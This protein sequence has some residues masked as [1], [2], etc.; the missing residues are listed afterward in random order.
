MTTLA[1][2]SMGMNLLSGANT[3]A[4]V[5]SAADSRFING[6]QM[7][8]KAVY[9]ATVALQLIP[10]LGAVYSMVSSPIGQAIGYAATALGAYMWVDS[11]D[12]K[13]IP[14]AFKALNIAINV[15]AVAVILSEAAINAPL[16]GLNIV[17]LGVQGHEF[18]QFVSG[19][20]GGAQNVNVGVNVNVVNEGSRSSSP[21][22]SD[23]E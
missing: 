4:A 22:P 1:V 15:L 8:E 20:L 18:Y 3:A 5:G 2:T 14:G 7:W 17:C 6:K 10:T 23:K 16:L 19:N 21:V 9:V 12:Q 11:P 13:L